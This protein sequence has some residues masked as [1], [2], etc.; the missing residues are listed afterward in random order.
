MLGA[1]AGQALGVT[2]TPTNAAIYNGAAGATTITVTPNFGSWRVAK[3]TAP[4]LSDPAKSGPDAVFGIDGIS[5][6][7][8]Y[9]LGLD[10]KLDVVAGLPTVAVQSTDWV[11]NYARPTSVTDVIYAVEVSTNLT[12]WTTTGVTHEL[13][14]SADGIAT[15][16]GRYPLA[17]APNVF[18]RL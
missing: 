6:L 4:E 8:K 9:A 1:G 3:F 11:Y 13:V 10:P 5:N 17:S 14:S 12:S 7:V 2:F 18:L 15:W 16:R